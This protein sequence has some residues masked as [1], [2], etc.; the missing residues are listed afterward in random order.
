MGILY[1][2]KEWLPIKAL[3]CENYQENWNLNLKKLLRKNDSTIDIKTMEKWKKKSQACYSIWTK[4]N[5]N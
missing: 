3:T 4:N 5:K 2:S 1:T